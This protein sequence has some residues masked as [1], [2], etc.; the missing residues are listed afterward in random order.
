[1]RGEPLALA[2]RREVAGSRLRWLSAA[3]VALAAGCT[4]VQPDLFALYGSRIESERVP[5]VV[6]H[7]ILGA[8]LRDARSERWPGSLWRLFF[9]DYSDLRLSI[10]PVTLEPRDD[11][12]RPV[13]FF[14]FAGGRDFYRRLLQ[15]LAGP[16]GYRTGGARPTLY[17]FYYDWRRSNVESAA[18]LDDLIERIRRE[19]GNPGLR[20]HIVAHSMGGLLVRYYERFGRVDVI[21]DDSPRITGEGGRK[22]RRIVLVGTPNFGSIT[23]LQRALDGGANRARHD[24]PRGQCHLAVDV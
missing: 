22:L 18:W 14:D 7:G 6:V 1:M 21:D 12:L 10:D 24:P 3:I 9:D 13:G 15:T 16:G 23:G 20:V 4:P 5:V 8:R 11:D 17:P 2:G 19:H